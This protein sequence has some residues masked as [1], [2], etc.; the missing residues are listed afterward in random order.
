MEYAIRLF[1]LLFLAGIAIAGLAW[2]VGAA[3]LRNRALVV[4][5]VGLGGLV[6]LP[7]LERFAANMGV[8][9]RLVVERD[10]HGHPI[11]AAA[12]VVVG[13]VVVAHWL[14]TRE[15]R[16]ERRRDEAREQE[17][18]RTRER[19]RMDPPDDAGRVS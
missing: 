7:I 9:L 10:F 8:Q 15:S 14:L 17:R 11:L 1:S 18:A 16:A 12:P 4:A 19:T 3:S 2:I 5:A 6:G 13:H